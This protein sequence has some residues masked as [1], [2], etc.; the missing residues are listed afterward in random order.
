MQR[1]YKYNLIHKNTKPVSGHKQGAQFITYF[2]TQTNPLFPKPCKQ[3]Q[4]G[5]PV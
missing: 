4:T 1:F 3:S 2:I 5:G